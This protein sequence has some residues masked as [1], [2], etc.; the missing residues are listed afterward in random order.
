MQ[1]Q[2]LMCAPPTTLRLTL[3]SSSSCAPTSYLSVFP[4]LHDSHG[5]KGRTSQ[6]RVC[7]YAL[8]STAGWLPCSFFYVPEPL[9]F[10]LCP[11]PSSL[12]IFLCTYF[13]PTCLSCAHTGV[14]KHGPISQRPRSVSVEEPEDSSGSDRGR[15]G[16]GRSSKGSGRAAQKGSYKQ[17]LPPQQ[18]LRRSSPPLPRAPLQRKKRPAL[19]ESEEEEEVSPAPQP[20]PLPLLQSLIQASGIH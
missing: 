8:V 12:S 4:A 5:R 20:Q 17:P 14:R 3:P 13:I 19:E 9:L 1:I 11:L 2:F 10:F 18:D 15:G 16:R 6:F 7:K